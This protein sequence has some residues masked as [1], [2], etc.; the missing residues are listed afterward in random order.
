[1]RLLPIALFVV[2]AAASVVQ[3]P[4]SDSESE[5]SKR[6]LWRSDPDRIYKLFQV[7]MNANNGKL[8]RALCVNGGFSRE[9]V[10]TEEE[11]L[12]LMR[13]KNGQKLEAHELDK[14][15]V[16][17]LFGTFEAKGWDPVFMICGMD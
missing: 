1:M 17:R 2:A 10:P 4:D 13:L 3:N 5:S 11:A 12:K 16:N 7:I 15:F 8:K 9:Q 14:Y 6:T